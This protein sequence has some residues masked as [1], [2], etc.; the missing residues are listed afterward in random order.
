M[1][2]DQGTVVDVVLPIYARV[3]VDEDEGGESA[4]QETG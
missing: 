4:S 3:A 2:S 1:S